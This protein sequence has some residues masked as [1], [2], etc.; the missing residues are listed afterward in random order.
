[1]SFM[2]QHDFRYILL[3]DYGSR[4]SFNN[5]KSSQNFKNL[6]NVKNLNISL[7]LSDFL[8]FMLLFPITSPPLSYDQLFNFS[9]TSNYPEGEAAPE[10]AAVFLAYPLYFNSQQKVKIFLKVFAL[11]Y[12]SLRSVL[13][14]STIFQ[15]FFRF[16]F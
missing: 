13:Q 14:I 15:A 16:R 9:L 8:F 7:F 4:S 5:S 11:L 2:F 10:A 6:F 3:N 12:L 1:M